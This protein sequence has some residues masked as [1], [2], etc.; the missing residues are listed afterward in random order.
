MLMSHES[1]NTLVPEIS[2]DSRNNE[3]TRCICAVEQDSDENVPQAQNTAD[4]IDDV[5]LGSIVV[6]D[7]DGAEMCF[8]I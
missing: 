5:M 7:E 1:P 8:M 6:R 4:S 2:T 3:I